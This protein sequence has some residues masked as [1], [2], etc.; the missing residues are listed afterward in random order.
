MQFNF[1]FVPFLHILFILFVHK[2][3]LLAVDEDA[4]NAEEASIDV[5]E[6][7]VNVEEA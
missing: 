4:T 3:K 6:A 7:S 1:L 5:E 2:A